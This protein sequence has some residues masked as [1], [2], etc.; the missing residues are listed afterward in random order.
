M[1]SWLVMVEGT[2]RIHSMALRRMSSVSDVILLRRDSQEK[3]NC[4]ILPVRNLFNKQY[5]WYIVVAPDIVQNVYCMV[6]LGDI[7]YTGDIWK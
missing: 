2:V 6:G 5:L 1:R 7:M 3:L 4:L